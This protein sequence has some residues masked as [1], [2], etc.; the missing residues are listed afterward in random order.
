MEENK[1]KRGKIYK[2]V[3]NTNGNIYIGSTCEPTLARRLVNHKTSYKC[4]LNGKSG[5]MSSFNILKNNDYDIVLIKNC[6]CNNK[7]ELYKRERHYIE[8]SDCVN[9]VIVGRSSKEYRLDN[10]EQCLDRCGKYKENNKNSI[11]I[12]RKEYRISRGADKI[13][14]YRE[15]NKEML[16]ERFNCFCG[17]KYTYAHKAEHMRSKGHNNFKKGVKILFNE[18]DTLFLQIDNI[19]IETKKLLSQAYKPS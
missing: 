3:D 9:K 17:G 13:K 10:L 12:Q 18:A 7:D 1:Y 4:Y 8:T 16:K 6:P 15:K 14:E 2:I 11:N 19:L 5:F